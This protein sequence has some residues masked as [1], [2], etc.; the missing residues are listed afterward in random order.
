MGN[1][2][3]ITVAEFFARMLAQGVSNQNHTALICP[4][5]GTVQSITDHIKAGATIDEAERAIGFA[6]VGRRTGAGAPS[7]A[8]KGKGCNWSLGGPLQIHELTVV[9]DDGEKHP[10]FALATPEQAQAHE[11]SHGN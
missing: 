9:T 7:K 10:R 6:C 11:A 1:R 8:A 4:A 3:E 5:C 2:E